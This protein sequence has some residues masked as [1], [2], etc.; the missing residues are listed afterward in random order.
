VIAAVVV[1]GAAAFLVYWFVLKKGPVGGA[2]GAPAG[3]G[4][5]DAPATAE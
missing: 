3:E 5:A 1:V 4:A 2:D